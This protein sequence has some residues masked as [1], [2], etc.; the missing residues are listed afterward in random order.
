M[1][2]C[3]FF[4]SFFLMVGFL[5]VVAPNSNNDIK[6]FSY[7]CFIISSILLSISWGKNA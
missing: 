4:G 6:N 3:N 1:K 5:A 7:F 2:A